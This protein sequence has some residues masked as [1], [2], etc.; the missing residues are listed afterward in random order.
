MKKIFFF[1]VGFSVYGQK[2][3]HST[4]AAQGSSSLL[5]NGI[6]VSQSIGQQSV[7]GT[8]KVGNK[9]VSQGFQQSS[10]KMTKK[11]Q[12]QK[13]LV[14]TKAFPNPVTDKVNFLFSEQIQGS[15]W[16]MIY[17]LSGRLLYS[18]QHIA[19]QKLLTI[20]NLSFAEGEYLVN[21]SAKNYNY[22]THLLVSR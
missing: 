9:V 22:S 19:E 7:T 12:L 18:K 16:V 2:L 8:Y 10:L 1:F 5:P 15:I 6:V 21:L 13:T 17:D 11:P 3:H 14:T 20:E 4:I